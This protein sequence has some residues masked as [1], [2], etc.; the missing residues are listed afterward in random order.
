M[1]KKVSYDSE[2]KI[3][4]IKQS[5]NKILKSWGNEVYVFDFGHYYYDEAINNNENEKHF[6]FKTVIKGSKRYIETLFPNRKDETTDYRHFDRRI[7][8]VCNISDEVNENNEKDDSFELNVKEIVSK[9]VFDTSV[10]AEKLASQKIG[11]CLLVS[12]IIAGNHQSAVW[13]VLKKPIEGFFTGKTY[14]FMPCEMC[15]DNYNGCSKGFLSLK[16]KKIYA[17]FSN[18]ED[19]LINELVYNSELRT[20][21]DI[22]HESIY[23]AI[24]QVFVRIIPHNHIPNILD[25]LSKVEGLSTGIKHLSYEQMVYNS[26]IE[27]E[28]S[29]SVASFFSY[30]ANRSKYLSDATI[31]DDATYLKEVEFR[32]VYKLFIDFDANRILLNHI[33]SKYKFKYKIVFMHKK[34]IIAADKDIFVSLPAGDLGAQAFYN[35]LENIISNTAEYKKLKG[36]FEVIFTVNFVDHL[37]IKHPFLDEDKYY[38]VEIWDNVP[39]RKS[40][41]NFNKEIKDIKNDPQRLEEYNQYFGIDE[42]NNK[43]KDTVNSSDVCAKNNEDKIKDAAD[44]LVYK[45]NTRLNKSVINPNTNKLRI[46]YHDLIEMEASAAYLRQEKLPEIEGDNYNLKHG[47]L[48]NIIDD[49]YYPYFIQ[50]FKHELQDGEFSL[51]YRFYM[52]KPEKSL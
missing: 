5:L 17:I 9:K 46:N 48:Y 51:G 16:E 2:K 15:P 25:N 33:S 6:F 41:S 21:S 22:Y 49:K 24:C 8:E 32:S 14:C 40:A 47:H 1:S 42:N 19:L 10:W 31:L 20:K 13:V 11:G 28:Q 30:V 36:V 12:S 50:A 43:E 18:I 35:I 26:D 37:D 23:A 3:N 34:S 4:E 52:K 38:L 29:Q 7:K 27:A 39:I 45:Q 44:L